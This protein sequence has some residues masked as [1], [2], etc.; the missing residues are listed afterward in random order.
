M[1][2]VTLQI[3]HILSP[4]RHH[5]FQQSYSSASRGAS[6]G[7]SPTPA[8][9]ICCL[10]LHLPS[11]G[12]LVWP[13]HPP[14]RCCAAQRASHPAPP[15]FS[16]QWVSYTTSQ[17]FS[18]RLCQKLQI[19]YLSLASCLVNYCKWTSVF[20]VRWKY[21]EQSMSCILTDNH[22]L[23]CLTLNPLLLSFINHTLQFHP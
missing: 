22:I 19:F 5:H 11:R 15:G 2:P 20:F 16:G 14:P 9:Q 1:R 8:C 10:V 6:A 17:K 7:D 21:L 12:G 3:V 18:V 13:H 4:G 23:D